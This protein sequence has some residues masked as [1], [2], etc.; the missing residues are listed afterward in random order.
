MNR[1]EYFKMYREKYREEL[2]ENAERHYI[3]HRDRIQ[4]KHRLYYLEHRDDINRKARE[5]RHQ[6]KEIKLMGL[7]DKCVI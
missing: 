4:V 3:K 7:E 2:A 1:R 6:I 5:K